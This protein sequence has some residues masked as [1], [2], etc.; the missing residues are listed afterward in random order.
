MVQITKT[1]AT[2]VCVLSRK[3][4][5]FADQISQRLNVRVRSLIISGILFFALALS[6]TGGVKAQCSA[7]N[8]TVVVNS[9]PTSCS[10]NNGSLT[11]TNVTSTNYNLDVITESGTNLGG[12][13]LNAGSS[14]TFTNVPVG[15][16]RVRWY[17]GSSSEVNACGTYT[18]TVYNGQLSNVSLSSTNSSTCH[19]NTGTITIS[20]S[21]LTSTDQVSIDYGSFVNISTYPSNTITGLDVGKHTI[22][23]R[24]NGTTCYRELFQDV[25][26]SSGGPCFTD[27]MTCTGVQGSNLWPNGSFG[28]TTTQYKYDG[29]SLGTET[30]YNYVTLGSSQPADGSYAIAT[31]T[32]YNGNTSGGQIFGVLA[33]TDDHTTDASGNYGYMMVV[34]ASYNKDVV[35]TKT[36]NNICSDAKYV[37]SA[38]V[39]NLQPNV[40]GNPNGYQPLVPILGFEVNG[41]TQDID[42][43]SAV[44]G[45]TKIGCTIQNGGTGTLLFSIRNYQNGGFGNDWAID[46]IELRRCEPSS[47]ISISGAYVCSTKGLTLQSIYTGS[48]VLPEY[49]WQVSTDG[50]NN[51]SDIA[52]AT[53]LST[54]V[55]LPQNRPYYYR[56]ISA[57]LGSISS[58]ACRV[59]SNPFVA[60]RDNDCDGYLDNVDLDNDND[61]IP[62]TVENSVNPF[63]DADGDGIINMYDTTPGSGVP[64]FVD[65]NGDGISD[66]FDTDAD[67]IINQF[68]L[69]ADNDGIPDLD[70]FR[71]LDNNGDGK[72]DALTDVDGDGL[73]D[74]YDPTC[75]ASASVC[76]S[77]VAGTSLG[78]ADLDGDG[79]INSLDLDSDNDGIPDIVEV[80]GSDNN[81]DARVD[82]FSDRDQDGY[83]D[84]FD[85]ISCKDTSFPRRVSSGTIISRYALSQTTSGTVTTPANALSAPD[86]ILCVMPNASTSLNLKLQDTIPAG[87]TLTLRVSRVTSG[88]ATANINYSLNGSSYTALGTLSIGSG[89]LTDISFV[90]TSA[91]NYIQIARTGTVGLNIDALSYQFA[92]LVWIIKDSS[93]CYTSVPLFKTGTD[94]NNDGRPDSYPAADNDADLKPNFLDMDSD[95]DGIPDVIETGGKDNNGNGMI[96][97]FTDANGNGWN[98]AQQTTPLIRVNNDT[99]NDNKPQVISGS[100]W[101]NNNIDADAYA[102]FLDLDSDNDGIPDLVEMGGADDDR[103][104]KAD[105]LTDSDGDG[106]VNIYDSDND[107]NNVLE[108]AQVLSNF[109][110]TSGPLVLTTS[111]GFTNG[112]PDADGFLNAYDLDSDGDGISDLLE[113]GGTDA[114]SDAKIDGL[115]D[116]NNNGWND[117][118][119]ST[120]LITPA[121]DAND[122]G[123]ADATVRWATDNDDGDRF[124][125]FIDIDSD[126][127]GIIDNVEAQSTT[128]FIANATTDTDGDGLA[129]VY[130]INNGGTYI[131]PVNT[132]T[133]DKKDFLDTDSDNDGSKDWQDG[134]ND[135]ENFFNGSINDIIARANAFTGPSTYYR[136]NLD[137]NANLRPDY[138][139]DADLDGIANYVDFGSGFYYDSDGDGLVDLL[140]PNSGG[141]YT[142]KSG[143]VGVSDE[144]KSNSSGDK[145]WRNNKIVVI[146]PIELNGFTCIRS[147]NKNLVQWNLLNND[148]IAIDV[149]GGS[150]L[151]NMSL[152]KKLSSPLILAASKYEFEFPSTGNTQYYKLVAQYSSG[153]E[154]TLGTCGCKNSLNSGT[155]RL[156]IMPN[157][158]TADKVQLS[159]EATEEGTSYI[160]VYDANGR[161]ISFANTTI[162]QGENHY[163][164]NTQN[165]ADGIYNVVIK[166]LDGSTLSTKLIVQ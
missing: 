112:D 54:T 142:G 12:V 113:V 74:I 101:Q 5:N 69:D 82:I 8:V 116:A 58:T 105:L 16:L 9:Y 47:S 63:A 88:T 147:S 97:N 56:I 137:A 66:V 114:N 128:L 53:S 13:S 41:V 92:P 124:A 24:K 26:V 87:T 62:N 38:W 60:Y 95:Q 117:A 57:E 35:W 94:L 107:N 129:N 139:D 28:T 122:N 40:P 11:F 162:T 80:F 7:S 150:S 71:G 44:G 148:A 31:N 127:D 64:A 131:I 21:S 151:N 90:T 76:L 160:F 89:T 143:L 161:L 45:W 48:F 65:S 83:A 27:A 125:N 52:G 133:T 32:D 132:D 33:L 145:D 141:K 46:D 25:G 157:P 119:E 55:K 115:T 118:Q 10:S 30:N 72:T 68:D 96:D 14:R 19:A 104:G 36:L 164:L 73:P 6:N 20:G 22:R 130:D 84:K 153:V 59:I 77:F 75:N 99:D 23:V 86:A 50:G 1:T 43:L 79:I 85:P 100:I 106:L 135:D 49:Q 121:N 17:I 146:L 152:T 42:T 140:D 91:T 120:A 70:E 81:N 98:D 156:N 18:Y 154:K 2:S 109:M 163:L 3:L 34:N 111:T 4:F 37:F 39:Y 159:W 61:G 136:N 51:W 108:N 158:A 155:P 29:P 166:H 144:P 123:Y 93:V 67:G 110:V 149:Y 78:T 134:L 102:N 15:S 138:L 126:D 165:Y 103:N